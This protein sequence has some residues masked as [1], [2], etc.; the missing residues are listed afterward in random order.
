MSVAPSTSSVR[1]LRILM[2]VLTILAGLILVTGLAAGLSLMTS[3]NVL[4]ANAML[5]FQLFGGGA[6]AD[7]LSPIVS[8][9]FVNLGIGLLIFGIIL[10]ALLYGAARLIGRIISLEVRVARLEAQT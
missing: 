10:S 5:G 1:G 8:G 7:L 9:F 4:T 6:I 2:I 3:A